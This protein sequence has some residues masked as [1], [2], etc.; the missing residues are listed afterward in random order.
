[1]VG[2]STDWRRFAFY[3]RY[4]EAI[5]VTDGRWTLFRWPDG[6][7]NAPLYWY[8]THPPRFI[9]AVATGSLDQGGRYPA[10]V[11]RGDQRTALYDTLEDPG[12]MHDRLAEAPQE[13]RRL[14]AAIRDLL[15]EIG[16][17]P[18][19]LARVGGAQP[20]ASRTDER[21]DGTFGP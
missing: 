10:V 8:S 7:D 2:S 16:A 17:P 5:N 1:M 12:Q 19:Q 15:T 14:E 11:S 21:T 9:G 3:G 6:A 18:E 13:V 20:V 4:G